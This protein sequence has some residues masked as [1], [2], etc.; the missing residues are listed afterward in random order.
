MVS[1]K[2]II[3]FIIIFSIIIF[4]YFYYE[5]FSYYFPI[6]NFIKVFILF[7]GITAFFFP[8]IIKKWRDGEDVEDIKNY[9]IEKYQKK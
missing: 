8:E 2:S 4:G 5:T 7:I 9:I 1:I 6:S 3:F